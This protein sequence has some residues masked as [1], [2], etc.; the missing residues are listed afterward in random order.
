MKNESLNFTHINTTI[1]DMYVQ[2]ALDWHIQ[3]PNF[4]NSLLNF[5]W[6]VTKYENDFMMFKLNFTDPLV[7]SP[8]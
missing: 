8:K 5:T 1:I 6:N 2:P 3:E 7:L 4:T